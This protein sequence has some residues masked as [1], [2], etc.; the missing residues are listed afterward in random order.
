MHAPSLFAPLRAHDRVNVRGSQIAVSIHDVTAWSHPELLPSRR[1]SWAK[2][3]GQ[4]AL[5]YADA[6]V[7]PTHAVAA[8]LERYLAFGDRVRVIGG[9]VRSSLALPTDAAERAERLEL[10]GHYLMALATGG[11]RSGVA[12][13]LAALQRSAAE[14]PLLLVGDDETDV[15][16]R[17]SGLAAERVRN[18]GDLTDDD[19]A[20]VFSRATVFVHASTID[21]F[22]TP[23][24]EAFSFGAPTIH[25]DAPAL[26][27]VAGDGGLSVPSSDAEAYPAALADAIDRALGDD[28]L[29]RTLGIL[30]ADRAKFFSWRATAESVWQLH[31]DL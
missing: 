26:V 5:R 13:L 24:L 9:A 15:Q 2:A 30:G 19:L 6:V 16:L 8:E 1:V 20:T 23:V 12:P 17:E 4:R 10:P 21:G 11:S 22:G 29:R 3:M 14:I 31:A 7:V 18:L 25:S 28:E 27:E